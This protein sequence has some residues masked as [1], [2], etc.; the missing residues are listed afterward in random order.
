MG[1]RYYAYA[2][3]GHVTDLVLADPRSFL[4]ADPLADAWGLESADGAATATFERAVPERDML[5][6]DKA[7]RQLQA[8]SAPSKDE[9]DARPAFRMFEGQVTMHHDGWEPWVRVLPPSDVDIIAKDLNELTD[10]ELGKWLQ[11]SWRFERVSDIGYAV[12][13]LQQARAFVS[14]LAAAN[15]GLV[16]LIG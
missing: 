8:F 13:Y 2:F 10:T 16:Y 14:N 7:W 11:D 5:Y 9:V 12:G 15:R 3:D 6:L 4:S 1:I